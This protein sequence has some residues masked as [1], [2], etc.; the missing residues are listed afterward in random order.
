MT[1]IYGRY[2]VEE[3]PVSASGGPMPARDHTLE[4]D[5]V[6]YWWKPDA[7]GSNVSEDKAH[8]ALKG[9]READSEL[10]TF[11][12]SG[13]IYLIARNEAAA[14]GPL[15]KLRSVGLFPASRI[16]LPRAPLTVPKKPANAPAL[17]VSSVVDSTLN[18][19]RARASETRTF[20]GEWNDS[21][22]NRIGETANLQDKDGKQKAIAAGKS[23]AAA[24]NVLPLVSQPSHNP[25]SRLSGFLVAPIVLA[26]VA[27][28]W[29]LWSPS[30]T[31]TLHADH[32]VMTQGEPLR[33]EWNSSYG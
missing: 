27:I 15:A 18:Q 16:A 2:E 8:E 17:P 22:Q 25:R 19:S 30:P 31:I 23:E 21:D 28:I 20:T 3:Q 1:R 9:F 7:A 32:T 10:Q 26:A 13:Y 5:V 4:S 11:A 29:L 12:D 33:L 24:S 6:I 14:Q